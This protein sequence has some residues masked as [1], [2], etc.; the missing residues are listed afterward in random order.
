[1]I[2]SFISK[3]GQELSLNT[4]IVI[5]ILIIVLVVVAYIFLGGSTT[6]TKQV[7]GTLYGATSG[8]DKDFAVRACEQRC[9][10]AK[11]MPSNDLRKNS[12]FCKTGFEVDLD[13]SGNID[14]SDEG[15][16]K[17]K[18]L[19]ITCFMNNKNICL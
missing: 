19:G 9:E 16:V 6:L 3:R 7:K 12:A 15:D 11:N 5:I 13:N 14:K 1:M 4:L 2:N 17:C 8:T 10:S 18:D